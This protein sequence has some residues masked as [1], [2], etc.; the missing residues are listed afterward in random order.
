M[1]PLVSKQPAKQG[2]I[3][4]F[5]HQPDEMLHV[6]QQIGAVVGRCLLYTVLGCDGSRP[7]IG[8]RAFLRF[9]LLFGYRHHYISF[10]VAR[11]ANAQRYCSKN[12][13]LWPAT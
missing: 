1:N 2:D 8:L 11:C 10:R 3:L 13:G 5:A 9:L 7:R 6:R 4:D 12:A